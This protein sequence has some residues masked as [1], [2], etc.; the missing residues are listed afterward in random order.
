M[1]RISCAA[2]AAFLS[3]AAGA[4]LAADY[5]T[6]PVRIITPFAAGGG[7]DILT[8]VVAQRLGQQWSQQ[9]LVENRPGA[10]GTIGYAAAAKGAPDGY[11]LVLGANPLGISPVVY[12]NLPYEARR[13][14]APISLVAVTPEVLVVSGA[15]GLRTAADLVAHSGKQPRKLNYWSA[16]SGTLA[17]L[18]AE[19][20]NLRAAMNTVHIAYKGSA[21][22]LTDLLGGQVD[23]LF[24][25]PA[26]I[27]PGL[28]AGKLRALAVASTQRSPQLPGLPAL[29]EAGFADLDFRIWVGL[30]APAG[31]P[32]PIIREA[33]TALVQ[34]MRDPATRST[35]ASQGWDVAGTAARE[36]AAFLD[37]EPPKLAAAAR[38]AGVKAD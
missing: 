7:I 34:A 12:P 19:P 30:L 36:F 28:Q 2:L 20:F 37:A 32:E 8:R 9:V 11:T 38:A 29:A 22:A 3:V 31:T 6:R 4:A 35:L 24:D 21:P 23:W 17:H 13:D 26:A 25:S 16:G 5:P 14:F 27:L 10:G 15:S 1:F 33:E 18:A